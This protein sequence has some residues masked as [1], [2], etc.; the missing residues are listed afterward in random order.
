MEF[1]AIYGSSYGWRAGFLDGDG[2]FIIQLAGHS[3][4]NNILFSYIEI[5]MWCMAAPR[6]TF[7]VSIRLGRYN[8]RDMQWSTQR[9]IELDIFHSALCVPKALVARKARCTSSPVGRL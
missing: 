6:Q 5:L 3:A 4:H 8:I 1:R 2:F 7:A 9:S